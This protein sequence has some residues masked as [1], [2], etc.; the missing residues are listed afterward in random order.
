LPLCTS[1]EAEPIIL[2]LEIIMRNNVF[3]CGDTFWLQKTGTAM[4]TPPA[5]MYAILY[6]G[7]HE[8]RFCPKFQSIVPFYERY[9]DDVIG[10][11][12]MDDDPATDDQNWTAFQEAMLFGKLTCEFSERTTSV[13]F[14]DM[15]LTLDNN[16]V[17]TRLYE[18]PLNLY[19][20]I[21]PH[22]AHPPGILRGMITGYVTRV[23]RLT[24]TNTD[25]EVAIRAFFHRLCA[26]GYKSCILRPLFHDALQRSRSRRCTPRDDHEVRAFLH[27]QYH[28]Y[29]PASQAIQRL[30]REILLSPANQ[31]P[32]ETMCNLNRA[33]IG[34]NR[35]IVA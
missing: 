20:Y 24:S 28:P 32:L 5:C 29:D 22:S 11:W 2:A 4:G 8:L 12:I 21:P 33:P 18:K 7:I 16:R 1:I 6:Y 27:L 35:L 30:F 9:I 3:K 15:T 19:L 23:H 25:C 10:L 17:L 34:I 26:R 31:Q 14:L 13:N